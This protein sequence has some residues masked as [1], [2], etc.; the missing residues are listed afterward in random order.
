MSIA[1]IVL[2]SIIH[3]YIYDHFWF[4]RL[5]G[6]DI[7]SPKINYVFLL[8]L[9]YITAICQL[10]VS[11]KTG[12]E[13]KISKTGKQ[14]AVIAFL[15]FISSIFTVVLHE[16]DSGF[17]M[18]LKYNFYLC[19]PI[20][21][22]LSVFAIFRDNELI[23]KTLL[24]LFLLGI[25]FSFFA[26]VLHIKIMA[27]IEGSYDVFSFDGKMWAGKEAQWL[28]R[29]SVPGVGPTNFPSM[30]IPL[31]LASIY[32]FR[33][34]D[35]KVKYFYA[36]ASLFLFYNIVRTTTRG[37]FISLLIGVSYLFMKGWF[38]IKN[39]L[40]AGLIFISIVLIFFV[41]GQGLLYR[42]LLTINQFIPSICEG[43]VMAELIEKG[44]HGYAINDI[45]EEKNRGM[46]LVRAVQHAS[47]SP[48]FGSGFSGASSHIMYI[49]VLVKGGLVLLVPLMLFIFSI[50]HNSR[51]IL[52]KGLYKDALS[53]D[54][55]IVLI[56]IFLSYTVEQM[57]VPAFVNNY[58]L[59]FGFAAA[60]ARN[61]EMEYQA[62]AKVSGAGTTQV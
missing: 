33:N 31:I 6:L 59:W 51:E 42:L 47:S 13:E 41:D 15:Y 20:M 43:G 32:F 18:V 5:L 56:A 49:D 44:Q 36:F 46:L 28:S 4:L 17:L 55:G 50:Y 40:S 29:F 54:L 3:F 48:V 23:K 1:I 8:P 38:K 58:W 53:K 60:W 37:A 19:I 27:D 25:I 34:S 14:L 9:F 26:V 35:G 22:T 21:L 7:Y 45:G 62:Q 10:V 30:L 12:H 57:F 39:P 61:C 52:H 16:I 24:V 11:I 2:I